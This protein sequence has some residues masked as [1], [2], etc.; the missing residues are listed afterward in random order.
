MDA[1]GENIGKVMPKVGIFQ[2][3]IPCLSSVGDHVK[4]TAPVTTKGNAMNIL[5]MKGDSRIHRDWIGKQGLWSYRGQ[6]R[7]ASPGSAPPWG[8]DQFGHYGMINAHHE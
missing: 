2:I 8:D 5:S 6:Q 7:S 3:G 1:R 4:N